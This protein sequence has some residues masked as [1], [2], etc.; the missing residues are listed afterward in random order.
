MEQYLGRD[1]I[2]LSYNDGLL[3]ARMSLLT[4]MCRQPVCSAGRIIFWINLGLGVLDTIHDSRMIT[5]DRSDRLKNITPLR[6]AQ[7]DIDLRLNFMHYYREFPESS[8]IRWM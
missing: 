6:Q 7:C 1:Q 8:T 5:G 4:V 3:F 2:N